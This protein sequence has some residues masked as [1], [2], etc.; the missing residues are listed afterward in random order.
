MNS[1]LSMCPK[2]Y[3][4]NLCTI[5]IAE[6]M[7]TIMFSKRNYCGNHYYL[8]FVQSDICNLA[9]IYF[10]IMLFSIYLCY[11]WSIKKWT[12][13]KGHQIK[14]QNNLNFNLNWFS[15]L[16]KEPTFPL[17]ALSIILVT[18]R[19]VTDSY[20]TRQ[21]ICPVNIPQVPRFYLSVSVSQQSLSPF[22]GCTNITVPLY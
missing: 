3:K 11:A 14:N 2:S 5:V 13:F 16:L 10:K 17:M 7:L 6:I 9:L 8:L 20:Y 19:N 18:A 15:I 22:L 21:E 4:I 12:I 1:G